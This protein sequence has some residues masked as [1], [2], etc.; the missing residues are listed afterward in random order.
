MN[1]EEK[2]IDGRELVTLVSMNQRR[3]FSYIFTLVPNLCDA[4]DILQET[5]TSMWETKD[6][7]TPGTDFVAWGISIAYYK[8]LDYRKKKNKDN[9]VIILNEQFSNIEEVAKK[10]NDNI[11]KMLDELKECQSKLS[12]P[13]RQLMYLKYTLEL[14]AKDIAGRINKSIRSVYLKISRVQLQLRNC[15]K[16]VDS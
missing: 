3:I 16:R 6:R 15:M 14:S 7:Y 5:V 12:V 9:Q 2:H 1:N 8:V 13:D 11:E 4:E 10:S